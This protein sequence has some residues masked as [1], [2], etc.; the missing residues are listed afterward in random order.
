MIDGEFLVSDW[1]YVYGDGGF[2]ICFVFVVDNKFYVVM[3][4]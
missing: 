3:V 4:F 1:F 2:V